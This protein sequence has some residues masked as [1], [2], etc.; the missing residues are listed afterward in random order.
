MQ[1]ILN[2][3]DLKREIN[4]KN[5]VL[6]GLTVAM[7]MI[8][9]SLS[10]AIL[11][12]L[13]PL[14]GLYAAFLMGLVTAILGG[15]PG[16]VSGGA[17]ATIVVLIALAASH[18]VEYLFAAVVLAGIL[19]LL[20]GIFKLGKFVRLIPQPVMYGFLNG[21]AVIIF[22]A[23]IAQFKI[24]ENGTTNWIQGSALYLMAGLTLLTILIV[25]LLPKITKAIPASLVAI[26]VVFGIVYFF[27][28]DTKK[29]LDIASVSGSLP[30]FHIPEISWTLKTLQIIFPYAL[31]MAG[32]GLIESLLTL[33]MVDEITNTKGKSNR[34][35][36]AQGIANITNG[37]F[38]GM[39]GC[40]MVAQ[41]LVNIGAGGRT[42]FSAVVGAITILIIIL[43][44][45]PVIEQIPMAALVGVM[46]MVAIGT[47]EWVSFR[48][49]NKMP[50]ADIL[51]MVLVTLVTIFLHNLALA[52]LIGVIISALV[53]AWESAK[54]IR[55]RRYID[56]NG[57]KH[58][59]IYG[60]LFFGST[61]I[62]SEKF[63]AVNDPD[64]V[65]ISFRE[66]S[67]LDMSAIECLSKITE[68]YRKQ[69]K[70]IY[71]TYLSLRCQ[72]MIKNAGNVVQV[73]II[74]SPDSLHEK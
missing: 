52:V 66:S 20:V 24:T 53:F 9:E 38:G 18:G 51:V 48:I 33:N 45:G 70:K 64:I 41:T 69:G 10:F 25:I 2:L 6:A 58:Y 73:N 28:I 56:D 54:R 4:Y 74:N 26:V 19:Q 67:V 42:R 30:S 5:E 61:T 39:G 7:T 32:V 1:K 36:T 16:M 55:A 57:I 71:L 44:G 59:D 46:M 14:T 62:F 11:A 12:G 23:Q 34:E 8:P 47:F 37:F 27:D 68:R 63:D 49:F 72:R 17:G 21:L 35:A 40:A 15:R 13:S 22:M 50:K 60:P 29:V 65:V 3:F 31:I 43:V